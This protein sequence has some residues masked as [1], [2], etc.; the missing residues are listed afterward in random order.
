[1]PR[2]V[3]SQLDRIMHAYNLPSPESMFN[4]GG[5]H[6][7]EPISSTRTRTARLYILLEFLGAYKLT[8]H[9]KLKRVMY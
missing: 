4:Q 7:R 2:M 9:E 8:E 1:M 3:D 5:A 6:L